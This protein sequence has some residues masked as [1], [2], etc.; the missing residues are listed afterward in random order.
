MSADETL[1]AA[2]EASLASLDPASEGAQRLS[3][4][5][6]GQ[7]LSAGR[8][9][10]ALELADEVLTRQPDDADALAVGG[11]AAHAAGQPARADDLRARQSRL[12]AGGV[13]APQA[14]PQPA[15]P[16]EPV[17]DPDGWPVDA[18]R[19]TLADV[20]GMQD[21]KR[22]VNR[23]F[24]AP[25]RNPALAD[26]F[27]KDLRGGLLLWGPPGAGKTYLARALAGELGAAFLTAT[28]AD[29]YSPY[30]GSSESNVARLFAQ[31]RVATPSV[32]FLD[33]VD[34]LGGKRSARHTDQGR[35]VV[36]QLLV[37]L[38]GMQSNRGL[39]LLAATNAP[40][41]V[42]S[43]LRRPGRLDRTVVVLPPDA[44]ARAA[45][46]TAEL[47]QR[48]TAPNLS[49]DA[50]VARTETYTGADLV[51]LVTSAAESA[52]ERSLDS[53]LLSPITDADLRAALAHTP[54]SAGPWFRQA[55]SFVAYTDGAEYDVLRGYLRKHRLG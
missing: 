5:L 11:A 33:E 44:P 18:E 23:A 2:L 6:A 34:A 54:A 7:Y 15:P 55:A 12:L 41:D 29:I 43:A 25:L 20:H 22:Q 37:E 24:L 1:L 51:S 46:L 4:H 49:V 28:P 31:A 35:G 13:D 39:F 53:G 38:D 19:L 30:F 26:A 10:R 47:S 8:P 16:L 9:A 40:W 14:A 48:P 27:A 36:N 21:A 32:V 42:D 45:L 52:L 17:A 3:V 50:V